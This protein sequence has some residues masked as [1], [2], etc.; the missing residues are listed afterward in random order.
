MG[1]PSR[2]DV[3]AERERWGNQAY[4]DDAAEISRE[5]MEDSMSLIRETQKNRAI[6]RY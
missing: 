4:M 3:N 5:P 2:T 1:E 6:A